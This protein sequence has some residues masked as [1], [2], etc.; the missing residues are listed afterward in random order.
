[1]QDSSGRQSW[2]HGMLRRLK[3]LLNPPSDTY[4]PSKVLDEICAQDSDLANRQHEQ[5]PQVD[6]TKAPTL[7]KKTLPER[8]I[9]A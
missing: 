4:M 6:V 2:P 3:A 9:A 5:Q 1:M 8:K 7:E